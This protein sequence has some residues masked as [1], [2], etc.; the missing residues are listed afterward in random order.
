MAMPRVFVAFMMVFPGRLNFKTLEVLAPS[1]TVLEKSSS[2]NL[3][4][5]LDIS[6]NK[7]ISYFATLPSMMQLIFFPNFHSV[8]GNLLLLAFTGH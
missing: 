1:V 4:P 8:I 2:M 7:F 5:F 3:R 6:L